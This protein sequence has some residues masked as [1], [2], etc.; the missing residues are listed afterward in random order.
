MERLTGKELRRRIDELG[1][2]YRR[3]APLLGLSVS[4]LHQQMRGGRAVSR[5]TELLVQVLEK[6][7]R[8]GDD[9][10]TADELCARLARNAT[11]NAQVITSATLQ[12]AALRAA[13]RDLDAFL[14]RHK[15]LETIVAM[16]AM[17]RNLRRRLTE[18][19]DGAEISELA[20]ARRTPRPQLEIITQRDKD[21]LPDE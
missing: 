3:A 4:G 5:Q 8:R 7:G 17:L 6:S 16:N 20:E 18:H 2:T 14:F 9:F 10:L 1:L 15:G 12:I 19:L 11:A 13:I 21:E